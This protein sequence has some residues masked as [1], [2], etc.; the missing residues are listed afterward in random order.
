MGKAPS[1]YVRLIGAAS[2]PSTGGSEDSQGSSESADMPKRPPRPVVPSR[3]YEPVQPPQSQS[4]TLK[5]PSI[6]QRTFSSAAADSSPQPNAPRPS[7]FYVDDQFSAKSPAPP[8]IQCSIVM[9]NT[10]PLL[11]RRCIEYLVIKDAVALEGIF[12]VPGSQ[13]LMNQLKRDFE[14]GIDVN[15]MD[16]CHDPMAVAGLLKLFYR[17]SK[18]SPIT[19]A[20]RDASI[21]S[22]R[23]FSFFT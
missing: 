10:V 23:M 12:R 15:L 7:Q 18:D 20:F 16:T 2:S 14:K 8:A 21:N 9:D 6:P 17:E 13:Q 22:T 19:P 4:Q 5:R 11:V 3:S 1:N